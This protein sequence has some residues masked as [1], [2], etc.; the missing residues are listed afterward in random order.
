MAA[1]TCYRFLCFAPLDG[2]GPRIFGFAEFLTAL[3]LMVLAWTIADVRYR[4]RLRT[5]PF[6][7]EFA[8]F[9]TV[10]ILGALTLLTDLWRAERWPILV[11]PL[12][13]PSAWQALL[14]AVFLFTFLGWVWFAFIVPPTYGPRNCL[15]YAQVLSLVIL[16][17][18]PT[19]LAVVADEFTRSAKAVI[20]NAPERPPHPGVDAG[21]TQPTKVA[22]VATQI[23]LLV[24][25]RR[26]CRAVVESSPGAA[27]AVFH[28]MGETKKYRVAVQ[29]FARN[30]VD[31]A[32]RN[33]DSFLYHETA[34]SESGMTGYMKP[35]TRAMFSN[36]A[37][38]EAIQTLFEAPDRWRSDGWRADAL[39]AYCR[40]V[41][42]TFRGYVASAF[43]QHSVALTGAVSR[44]QNAVSDLHTL[45]GL[46]TS[47]YTDD[48]QE[49]LRVV[50][51]FAQDALDILTEKEVPEQL[52]WRRRETLGVRDRTFYDTLADTIYWIMAA[53]ASVRSPQDLCWLIQYSTV[54]SEF[55]NFGSSDSPASAVVRFKVRRR[56]YDEI[57]RMDRF[58][59][60]LSAHILGLCLNVMGFRVSD[61]LVFADSRALHKAVLSWTRKNF[62]RLHSQNP[63]IA[64]ACL[65]EGITYDAANHRLARRQAVREPGAEPVYVYFD[66]DPWPLA[67][68][69]SPST[70]AVP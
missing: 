57:A 40:I 55:F 21:A 16:K 46:T 14:G 54:W 69:R 35:L 59:N 12:I 70:P 34:G 13:T 23:L 41:L 44:I 48:I 31:E 66:V 19:E 32:L 7:L 17:G 60:Y 49:R 11:G 47:R 10:G 67:R 65:V 38:V 36:Y 8:S 51:E 5:A 52:I 29:T 4:F 3:A 1:E 58:P 62:A 27:L 50:V 20:L 61:E 26:F 37:M 6:P 45:D 53:A 25:D 9:A 42:T 43:G 15:R 56:L 64:E 63:R 24:G 68:G 2:S 39:S 30:I 18:A 22:A 28:F 33:R